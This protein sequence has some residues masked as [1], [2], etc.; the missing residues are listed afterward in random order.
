MTND[1]SDRHIEK[2]NKLKK[3]KSEINKETVILSNIFLFS[4]ILIL[5]FKSFLINQF[6]FFYLILFF[7]YNFFF[8]Y[9]RFLDILF[10]AS[11]YVIRLLYGAE[12]IDIESSKIFLIFFTS[13]FLILALFKRMIQISNNNL[14]T[15]NKII[16]YS[17]SNFPFIKKTIVVVTFVNL[18]VLI[19]FLIEINYPNTFTNISAQETNYDYNVYA[20]ILGLIIY[21]FWLL[22]IIN[23][24]FNEK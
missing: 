6:I 13:I 12:L 5:F 3:R 22:R 24:V 15:K 10:L 21:L 18:I 4:V 8:K 19:I 1:F 20:L 14:T 9:I 2:L 16:K 23:M 11:F 7:S 17:Y